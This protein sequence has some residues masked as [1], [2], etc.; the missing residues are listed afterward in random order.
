MTAR[1]V[2]RTLAATLAG[3]GL[4]A[5]AAATTTAP[6]GAVRPAA[7]HRAWLP[8]P[9]TATVA[10]AQLGPDSVLAVVTHGDLE[11]RGATGIGRSLEVLTPDGVRHP[12]YAVDLRESPDGW[13]RG[14]FTLVDWRP[15]QHTALL[16]VS[17]G[18]DGD[19]AVSYDLT[20]GA[21]REVALPR[22]AMAVGLDPKGTGVLMTTYPSRREA[23]RVA[24][25]GWDGVR[26]W[27]P[28]RA[29]G[30]GVTSPD[31]RTL[32]TSDGRARR[33]WV[34]DLTTRTSRTVATM[35]E[36]TPQRWFDA[37]SVIAT[38]HGR[39]GSQLRRVGLDGTSSPLALRH[40]TTRRSHH[41]PVFDDADLRSVQGRTYY[42]SYGGCGGAF[43]TRQTAAGTVRVVPV[44][45]LDGSLDLVG[46]RG[47]A[48]V[49]THEESCDFARPRAVL[50]LFDPVTRAE[51]VLTRLARDEAWRDTFL[52]TEVRAWSW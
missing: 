22:R 5:V 11:Q 28:G 12:V 47:D 52:A 3:L 36:C 16:R 50:T 6:A 15:E 37:A 14:D 44:P 20:T 18:E 42:E 38:C 49:I 33:W 26:A 25:V 1:S 21:Q 24:T 51:T 40:P 30:V 4:A 41:G 46:A 8:M 17:L 48:L 10:P 43:L 31:G 23:G 35:G 32:V 2:R 29:D 13:F 45:D 27:L 19:K 9:T 39:R 7:G 34:T